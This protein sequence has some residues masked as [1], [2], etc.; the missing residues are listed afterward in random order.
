[1]TKIA[2]VTHFNRSVAEVFDLLCDPRNEPRYNP[3]ILEARKTTPGPIG[4]GT[5]FVQQVKSFGRVGNVDIEVVECRL[6]V[7]APSAGGMEAAWAGNGARG[8][9]SGA[10][11]LAANEA[12]RRRRSGYRDSDGACH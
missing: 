3:L 12:V 2:G 8:A 5:R 9:T 11:R 10:A 6:D 7:A 1:M 4:R